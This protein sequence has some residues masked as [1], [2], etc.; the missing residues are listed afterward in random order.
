MAKVLLLDKVSPRAK[1]ILEKAG[2]EVDLENDLTK[3]QKLE[4]IGNYEAVVIRSATKFTKEFVD[5]A[6]NLKLIVR[7]GAG[8]DNIDKPY[9]AEKGV[10]V[11]NTPG[12][13]SH[14]VAELAV[15]H[16]FSLARHLPEANATMQKGEWAKKKLKGTE[17]K[18]K[19]VGILGAGK[20]GKDVAGMCKALGMEV[21]VYDPLLKQGD[22]DFKLAELKEVLEKSDYITLH[23]PVN[24]ETRGM[25]GKEQLA[26]M[27]K[28]A[29]IINCARG[30]IIVEQDLANAVKNGVIKGAAIDVYTEE[31]PKDNPLAGVPGIHLTPHLGAATS[32]AQVNCAVAAAEQ[33]IAYFEKEEIINKVN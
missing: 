14:A 3:E 32:E 18:G 31:P 7:G 30:G 2:F 12:Q 25:I 4:R 17:L 16:M 1:E 10:I 22:V 28:S 8:T 23:L 15:A 11:E 9:A 6:S 5:A 21:I 27:K 29:Y 26:K 19:K 20:I 24:D 33:I 13:N